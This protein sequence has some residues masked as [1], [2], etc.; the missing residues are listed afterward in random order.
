MTKVVADSKI[1]D[2]C[3][4]MVMI[5]MLLTHSAAWQ[6][7]SCFEQPLLVRKGETCF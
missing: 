5:A 6:D 2:I 4:L 3:N 7:C 1:L